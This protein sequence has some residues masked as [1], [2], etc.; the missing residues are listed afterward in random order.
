MILGDSPLD[1]HVGQ[2]HF[3]EASRIVAERP[4]KG[5][6]SAVRRVGPRGG[7]YVQ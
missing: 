2:H 4:Q 5:R 3:L 7:W 6:E 1:V